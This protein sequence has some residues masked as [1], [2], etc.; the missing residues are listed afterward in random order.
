MNTTMTKLLGRTLLAGSLLLAL[1]CAS[2]LAADAGM[3]TFTDHAGRAHQMQEPAG[4]VAAAGAPA[5]ILLYTLVPERLV[6]WNRVLSP[7]ALRYVPA[8][9]QPRVQIENLPDAEDASLD[10]EFIALQPELILDYGSLHPDY[11]A[12]ADAVQARLDVPF[13]L[14]DGSLARIPEAYRA[15]GPVLA[16][17]AR[18]E[19]LA[20][21]AESLLTKYRGKLANQAQAQRVYIGTAADGLMPGFSDDSANEVFAWLGLRN[22]VGNLADATQLPTSFEQV[23]AWQPDTIFALSP[24]MPAHITTAPAWQAVPAVAAGRIYSAPRLPFDW[25][26]RPPSVNRLLG[27]VWVAMVLSPEQPQEEFR[28]DLQAIFKTFLHRELSQ[29]ELQELLESE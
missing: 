5:E 14:F 26:A 20:T 3:L 27:L 2:S 25:V 13:V 23:L 17:E 8:P 24:A 9:L 12:R 4:R 6:G 22:V 19:E 11:A 28:N 1:P 18:A 21:L 29:Q 10:A 15:L 16:V 7:A